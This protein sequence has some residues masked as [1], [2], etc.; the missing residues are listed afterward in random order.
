VGETLGLL[1]IGD[2]AAAWRRVTA[3]EPELARSHILYAPMVSLE[4][5]WWLGCGAVTAAWQ[6]PA[7]SDERKQYVQ[8]AQVAM[9]RLGKVPVSIGRSFARLLAA[10]IAGLAGDA[11]GAAFALREAIVALESRDCHMH[12][13]AA[14]RRLGEVLGGTEGDQ[15]KRQADRWLAANGVQAPRRFAAMLVPAVQGR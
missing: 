11:E 4:A 7:G 3:R 9:R 14:R 8:R 1:Y 13:V 6:A 10:G 5:A 15:L 12:A 2:G